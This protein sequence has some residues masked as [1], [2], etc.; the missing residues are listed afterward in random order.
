MATDQN[1]SSET[2]PPPVGTLFILTVYAV[3][4]AGM[5]GAMVWG[6]IGR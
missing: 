5:W 4:M 6:L 3:I 2:T 1:D